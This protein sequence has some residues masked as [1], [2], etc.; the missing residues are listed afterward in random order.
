MTADRSGSLT[1]TTSGPSRIRA[2][3]FGHGE[4]RALSLST[5]CPELVV[6]SMALTPGSISTDSS[7]ALCDAVRTRRECR[8]WHRFRDVTSTISRAAAAAGDLLLGARCAGCG[9]PWWGACPACRRQ[10]SSRAP[11]PTRPDPAPPGFPPTVTAGPYDDVLRGLI[12]AHKEEQAL[13]LTRLLGQ[14]LAGCIAYL[15]DVAGLT[16]SDRLILV[17]VPS[18]QG[19]VAP[20]RLRRDRGAGSTGRAKPPRQRR[21]RAAGRTPH[22]TARNLGPSRVGSGGAAGESA[23][24]RAAPP[25][26]ATPR[27]DDPDRRRRDHRCQPHR[28]RARPAESRPA[29]DRR[30]HGGGHPTPNAEPIG[31]SDSA[32]LSLFHSAAATD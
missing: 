8:P 12:T 13:Q 1:S 14:L 30:L 26:K 21:T 24:E 18:A 5:S 3:R 19:G 27:P 16:P 28:S 4:H 6:G 9:E 17:A 2:E 25:P 10:V 7:P 31:R 15:A 20:A 11:R 29:A 32:L 22:P 23:G